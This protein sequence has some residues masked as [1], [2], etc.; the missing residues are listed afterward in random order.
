MEIQATLRNHYKCMVERVSPVEN[1]KVSS[2]KKCWGNVRR[3]IA[4]NV[5]ADSQS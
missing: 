4:R 1:V 5:K 2:Y 3:S